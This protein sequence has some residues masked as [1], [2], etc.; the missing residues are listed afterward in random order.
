M[1][2]LGPGGAER[3]AIQ[4][5][6]GLAARG[7][8]IDLLTLRDDVDDFYAVPEGLPRRQAPNVATADRRWWD[9]PG[10]LARARALRRAVLAGAPEVVLSFT[11]LT[12]VAVLQA[13]AGSGLPVVVSEQVDPR[14]M[15]LG[16]RW[17]AL[18]RLWYPAAARVV[19]Q[20]EELERWAREH[21]PR[22]DITVAVNPVAPPALDREPARPDW[23]GAAN[24]VAMGRLT[25]QKGFDLLL[26]VFARL[27]DCH[28]DWSLTI[29]GEGPERRGLEHQVR[30]LGLEGR[31]HLVGL[32]NPPWNVLSAGDVFAFPSRFEGF[33]NALME[34]MACGL[35]AVS[36]S[37]PTGPSD[38]IRDGVDGLLVAVGDLGGFERALGSLMTDPGR[39]RSM[40]R[41][42]VEVLDRFGLDHVT[43]QWDAIVR[44]VDRNVPDLQAGQGSPNGAAPTRTPPC[45]LCRTRTGE[46]LEEVATAE[47]FRLL[48]SV[49]HAPVSEAVESAHSASRVLRR[50][51][52]SSCGLEHF[53]PVVP[54]RQE[55]YNELGQVGSYYV[56]R[57]EFEEVASLLESVDRVLDIGA[58]DGTFLAGIAHRVESAVGFDQSEVANAHLRA[59]GLQAGDG[60]LDEFASSRAGEFSV[61]TAFQVL[62]HVSDVREIIEP[63]L[64]LL[65][66]GGRLFISVPNRERWS[67]EPLEPLDWPPH[68]LSRWSA[69]QFQVL[70]GV[71]DLGLRSLRLQEVD[72]YAARAAWSA[73]M[74][75]SI[76]TH[77]PGSIAAGVAR[78]VAR[79][80]LPQWRHKRLASR[81]HWSR[82]GIVGHTMLVELVRL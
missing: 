6:S 70:A 78:I 79:G 26:P 32:V 33:P 75:R 29:L 36:F 44:S 20:T 24:I 35:P 43:S 4:I 47:V 13:M 61:I 69:A 21:R 38:I 72:W 9:V 46:L 59:S 28:P 11:D 12:N 39:R 62:E 76:A 57:W 37:C 17:E 22:W 77:L 15:P 23:F 52:C 60:S 41:R 27:A 65:A 7:Y 64:E 40:G 71:F 19:V 73:S 74:E 48:R 66:P 63:A 10:Q 2:S 45:P 50:V 31:V 54:G 81:S 5:A 58:G 8:P 3:A 56:H 55:F 14:S 68:H 51:R 42:A 82:R 80:G 34:A 1:S 30:V 25:P 18:R 16:R 67:Q 53:D 49:W